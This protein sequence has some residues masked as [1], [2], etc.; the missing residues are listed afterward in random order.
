MK[1]VVNIGK[2]V[3]PLWLIGVILTSGIAAGVVG[4][5]IWDTITV[6]LEVEEPLEILSYPDEL[7]LFPGE[8][9][10]FNVTIMNDAS[11]DYM[12]SLDFA[13]DNET[14]QNDYVT[15]GDD[16]YTVVSGLQNLTVWVSVQSN[17][18]PIKA[19]LAISFSRVIGHELFFDDF[20][21]DVADG[22]TEHMGAW[23]VISGEYRVSVPGIVENGLSTVDS[24]I[25]TDCVIEAKVRFTDAVG[26]RAEL[27]F[28]YTDNERYYTFGLSNEYDVA[29]LSIYS[30]G[31][32]EYGDILAH[33]G[34][35]D[36]YPTETNTEY[37][38]K[39]EIQGDMFKGFINGEEVCSGTDATYDS[40]K[41]G[42]R[43]RRA[44]AF[45]DDFTVTGQS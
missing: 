43:A 1:A 12:V 41:V 37:S 5:Y 31:D 21:D 36:S 9:E 8:T 24:L 10:E 34:G 23:S 25:L 30:P 35:D 15:F 16:T 40:G 18:P 4:Y 32:A 29:F 2:H 45:F 26:F 22:W 13:L 11:V 6:D 38:L 7:D 39:V 3:V 14:Y 27:V 28:R 42:L 19:A 17:A 20:E 33:S 44:D